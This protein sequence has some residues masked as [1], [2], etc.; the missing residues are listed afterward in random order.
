M[1]KEREI[2][3]ERDGVHAGNNARI[4]PFLDQGMG[5]TAFGNLGELIQGHAVS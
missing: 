2:E 5:A 4:W 1:E 3:E